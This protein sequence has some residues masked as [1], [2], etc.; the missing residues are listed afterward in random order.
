[1]EIG[2]GKWQDRL[3]IAVLRDALHDLFHDL[4]GAVQVKRRHF[5]HVYHRTPCGA[6][7]LLLCGNEVGKLF[8][9]E[10]FFKL[11]MIQHTGRGKTIL[12]IGRSSKTE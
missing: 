5:S 6:V 7:Y 8:T 1:M 9:A 10:R 12:P 2:L 4:L 3:V 11:A